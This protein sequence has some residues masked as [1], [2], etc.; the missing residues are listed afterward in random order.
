MKVGPWLVETGIERLHAGADHGILIVKPRGLGARRVGSWYAMMSHY[1]FD[2]LC[3]KAMPMGDL[4][5]VVSVRHG[6]STYFTAA[7]LT[8]QLKIGLAP[9]LLSEHEILALLLR[10]RGAA[11]SQDSWYRVM[12]LDHMIRLLHAAGYEDWDVR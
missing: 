1:D 5:P 11:D 8:A 10:P 9:G 2:L 4:K 3:S 7:T 12:C 6:P